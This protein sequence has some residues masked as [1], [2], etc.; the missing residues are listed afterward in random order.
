MIV[1]DAYQFNKAATYS[2]T[3]HAT[4]YAVPSGDNS[5]PVPIIASLPEE[6]HTAALSGSLVSTV[7]AKRLEEHADYLQKR[8]LEKRADYIGC[9]GNK[10]NVIAV[11]IINAITMYGSA[12]SILNAKPDS[13]RYHKWFGKYSKANRDLV[14]THFKKVQS[15]NLGGYTYDCNCNRPGVFGTLPFHR[16]S[17]SLTPLIA[18]VYANTYPKINLCPAFWSAPATG[19]DSRAGTLIHE[20]THFTRNGGTEDDKYGQPLC[21]A[22][23]ITSPSRAIMN[24]DS[25]E[26]FAENTP[27]L[28]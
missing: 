14:F 4:F 5:A 3:P 13:A 10:K 28:N 12:I 22:L 19:T 8:S 17:I 18:W 20:S 27:Y 7:V 11:A 21:A 6:K 2:I 15:S 24:A 23:A 16:M 1:G 9:V 26:F 25:H